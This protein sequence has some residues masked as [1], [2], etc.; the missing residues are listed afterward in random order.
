MAMV[1]KMRVSPTRGVSKGD[2]ITADLTTYFAG[3]IPIKVE[4]KSDRMYDDWTGADKTVATVNATSDKTSYTVTFP[5]PEPPFLVLADGSAGKDSARVGFTEVEEMKVDTDGDGGLETVVDEDEGIDKRERETYDGPTGEDNTTGGTTG[6]L[7]DDSTDSSTESDS[8][9]ENDETDTSDGT[10]GGL[11]DDSTD[12]STGSD[13]NT[14]TVGKIPGDIEPDIHDP[15]DTPDVVDE[16]DDTAGGSG[17][18]TAESVGGNTMLYAGAA[19][20]AAAAVALS[21][22][23]S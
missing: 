4:T 16:A 19:A 18:G 14:T 22:R 21:R 2:T 13:D 17:E 1:A 5:A 12:S 8:T 7:E 11:E 15:S 6:G 10:T 20:V 23:E 9:D 3:E